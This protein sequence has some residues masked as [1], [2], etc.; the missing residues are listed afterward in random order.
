MVEIK[1]EIFAELKSH[2]SKKEITLIVWPRQIGKTTLMKQ[3]KKELD[4]EWKKTLF[5]NLDV[6][7]DNV[8]FESQEKLLQK[9]NLEIWNN[10]FVFIDEIQKKENAGVFLKWIYDLDLNYKFIVSGSGSLELKEKIHE[11]LAGRKRVFEC[12]P[13][14]FK[15]FVNYKTNYKYEWNLDDFFIIERE[16]T[17]NYL[18]EYLNFWW[19]PRIVL[20]TEFKE[21]KY[22][23]DEIYKSYVLKDISHLL[24]VEKEDAFMMMLKILASQNWQIINYNEISK[25]I[26]INEKTLKNYIYYAEN[27]FCVK[28][29]SP[30][31]RN[32]QKEV[33][34]A[35]T[36]YFNDLWIRNYIIG[37]MWT[38]DNPINLWFVFQ[39]FVY[40]VL[41]ERY[42][43][44]NVT[45]KFWRTLDKTEVDF[46]LENWENVTP[47]EVKYSHLKKPEVSKSFRS[48]IEKYSPKEA[49]IINLS[50]NEKMIIWNSK[51]IFKP[52]Y[53]LLSEIY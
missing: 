15:E 44:T 18:L 33:I 4:D 45:I 19:Y 24:K 20:E 16:K 49:I 1:R 27:T 5:L 47:I 17:L 52:F 41:C 30:F 25:Q 28:Q 23:I 40:K 32:K 51:V 9:I 46:V 36:I 11:S 3:L 39:N 43:D 48:F 26:W 22:I 14:N 21:K 13:I 7:I 34:K 37:L 29:V 35:K 8:F 6:E 31:F 38:L 50:L 12:F 42:Y 10:W 2:L 53:T